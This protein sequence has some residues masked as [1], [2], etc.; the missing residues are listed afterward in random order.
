MQLFVPLRSTF[1]FMTQQI[2]FHVQYKVCQIFAD[3]FTDGKLKLL[4][5]LETIIG[6]NVDK[7]LPGNWKSFPGSFSYRSKCTICTLYSTVKSLMLLVISVTKERKQN[8]VFIN[9]L[10][11]GKL[12]RKLCWIQIHLRVNKTT[13]YQLN[14]MVSLNYNVKRFSI[15]R[16]HFS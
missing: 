5:I 11:G 12:G 2:N 13:G 1:R 7:W 3:A 14:C 4:L 10:R 9:A 8:F 6:A 16:F 15:Y